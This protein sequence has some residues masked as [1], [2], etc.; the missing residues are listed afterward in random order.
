MLLV[1]IEA[2][3][4]IWQEERDPVQLAPIFVL[5]VRL[6]DWA[7]PEKWS[8]MSP[9]LA[10][11]F[12]RAEQNGLVWSSTCTWVGHSDVFSRP[13]VSFFSLLRLE[14]DLEEH[15][16]QIFTLPIL[17]LHCQLANAFE[18]PAVKAAVSCTAKLRLV[19]MAGE[20]RLRGAFARL[21]E[22]VV[23]ELQNIPGTFESFKE[24][25]RKKKK[26]NWFS[27]L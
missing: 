16:Y 8:W 1:G 7:Y 15:G 17:A 20:C 22:E 3:R 26:G 27:S 2:L 11:I 5:P 25:G 13:Q 9:H 19:R 24:A 14:E 12:K 6:A 18:S 21:R 10:E 4:S 23:Q